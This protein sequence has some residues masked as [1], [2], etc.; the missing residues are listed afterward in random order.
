MKVF[1]IDSEGRPCLPT[2]PRR[3]R[4]LLDQG[5]ATVRQVVP[6]TIQL[7]RTIENP[8]GS[9]EM[10]VDDGAK[11]VGIAVKNMVTGEIVF[12]GQLDHRQD[13]SRKVEQ[14]RNYRVARRYRLRNRQPRFDNRTAV[15][16][17]APSLRQ[18]KEAV[19]RVIKDLRKRLNIVKIIVEEVFFNHTKYAYGKF[20]SLVEVGKT[21]LREQIEDLGLIYEATH[22][23]TTKETRLRLHLSKGHCHDACA[24]VG[25]NL[26]NA[27]EFFIKP[28]RA[29]VWEANPTKTCTEKNG[30]RH[31]D[32]V[33]AHHKLGL[34]IG[35]IRSLKA[36]SIMLRTRFDDNFPVS[37]KKSNVIQRFG[38]L[39]YSY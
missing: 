28:R 2:K 36:K 8:V 7:K 18:R 16:K 26:I 29:K 11:H 21:Y 33:L 5:R 6:F 22:G 19:L 35:S 34:V 38:G 24:I 27:L 23:Y 17:L 12:Q 1:V 37:Y 14:R 39:I 4:Q 31:Y 13:V 25:S 9:F 15:G 30:F 32:L 10:G 20:F 3:A